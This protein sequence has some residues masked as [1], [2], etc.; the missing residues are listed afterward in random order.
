MKISHAL[1]V[2]LG[3]A[4][5]LTASA[6]AERTGGEEAGSS[7]GGDGDGDGD[8]G[9]D[10]DGD[11]DG[12]QGCWED[13]SCPKIDILFVV[14]NSGLMAEEQGK[15]AQAATGLVDELVGM[16]DD[17]GANAP[18]DVNI[19]VTTTDMGHPACAPFQP[20][21]YEPAAGSP[22]ATACIDRLDGFLT[23][24]NED[25]KEICTDVCPVS[26]TPNDPF[27]HFEGEEAISNNVT[28]GDVHAALACILPQGVVG[29]GYESP[30]ESMMQ[31]LNPAAEWNVGDQP[32]LRDDATLAIAILSDEADCSVQSPAGYVHFMDDDSFW[33]VNPDTGTK[34]QPTS[35]VCWNAGVECGAP[36]ADGI[37]ADCSAVDHDVL[38][39]LSR[40]ADYLH[41]ELI[42][43]QHK[44]V[45]MLGVLGIPEV[46]EHAIEAPYEPVA[47]GIDDLVYHRWNADTWPQGDML[48]EEEDTVEHK[49]WMFG[50]GPGCTGADGN[51]EFSGQAIP[52]VRMRELCE[53]LD[54]DD[55]VACCLESACDDDYAAALTCLRGM[56]ETHSIPG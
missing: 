38:H 34:T 17:Q 29:C 20:D 15:L 49:Q 6:C 19:M 24:G 11:G 23:V 32:F 30:L 35:A 47:G 3:S 50:I 7:E 8:G 28:G 45:V 36:D 21:G 25:F 40:Y 26:V 41:S 52:P 43:N 27:I 9:G 44:P 16:I 42:E 5:A 1:L 48:P 22:V 37:Y 18:G 46:T 51:G 56:I 55:Q 54:E 4:L 10:G 12:G 31:A 13:D 14:D 33:E 2:A 39:D 53:S